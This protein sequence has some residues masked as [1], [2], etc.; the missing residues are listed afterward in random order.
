[1]AK[2]VGSYRIRGTVDDI[3]FYVRE[4]E[5]LARKKS[6]LDRKRFY[7]DKA[8]VGSRR[9][10]EA[11]KRASPIASRLYRLLPE[12]KKGRNVFQWLV[13][14]VKLLVIKGWEEKRIEE[15]FRIEYLGETGNVKQVTRKTIRKKNIRSISRFHYEKRVKKTENKKKGIKRKI[16]GVYI[17]GACVID[18]GLTIYYA[19]HSWSSEIC[20]NHLIRDIPSTVIVN[21]EI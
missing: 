7:R 11:L 20:K 21:A 3:C 19:P 17:A 16:P 8:F 2:Q 9:S 15:W 18:C 4:G 6:S 1:M 12:G 13:G 10:C 14:Q 5:W